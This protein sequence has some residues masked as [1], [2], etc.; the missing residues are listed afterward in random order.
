MRRYIRMAEQA[1]M[2]SDCTVK[3]GAIIYRGGHPISSTCNRRVTHPESQRWSVDPKKLTTIHAE[4]RALILAQS[5]LKGATLVSVRLNGNRCS[6]PCVMC[7]SLMK[8][9]GISHVIYFDGTRYIKE[10]L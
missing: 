3:H 9:A 1:A 5:Q 8:E 4:Q 10:R 6:K 2:R 7:A